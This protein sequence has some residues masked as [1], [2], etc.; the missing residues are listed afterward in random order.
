MTTRA[1]R[2]RRAHVVAIILATFVIVGSAGLLIPTAGA[3]VFDGAFKALAAADGF[4]VTVVMPGVT[5]TKTPVDLGGPSTQAAT[6]SLGENKGFASFPYP[7]DTAVTAPGIVRGAGG[8]PAPDYPLYVS[9]YHPAVPK[10]EVGSGPYLI[11]SESNDSSSTAVASIGLE[12]QGAGAAGLAKSQASTVASAENVVAK[13]GSDLTGLAVGPLRLGQVLSTAEVKLGSDG[14]LTRTA[15]TRVLGAM[16]GDTPVQVTPDG[17]TLGPSPVP[18]PDTAAVN[19]ALTQAGVTVEVLP[20]AETKTGVVAPTVRIAQQDQSGRSI[21]Y[22]LGAASAFVEGEAAG[23]SVLPGGDLSVIPEEG[24][25]PN[26]DDAGAFAGRPA[27]ANAN[28]A[29]SSTDFNAA[30]PPAASGSSYTSAASGSGGGTF[31]SSGSPTSPGLSSPETSAAA[32]SAGTTTA[33]RSAQTSVLASRLLD[34]GD[35]RPIY[36]VFMVAAIVALGAG[37][38][39]GLLNRVLSRG[40]AK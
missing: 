1:G 23:S 15:D 32:G 30:P 35:T 17:V 26:A 6:T 39:I 14:K 9:S 16:V 19:A 34:G 33:R 36:A 10:Q 22:V 31:G 3:A 27:E 28:A 11:R 18:R 4:R 29:S 25:P 5:V 40:G 21:T 2:V 12:A 20:R 24:Q 37:A 13:A 38:G 8:V 7:G